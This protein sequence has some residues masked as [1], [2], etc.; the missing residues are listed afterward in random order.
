VDTL[1]AL[2]GPLDVS[3]DHLVGLDAAPAAPSATRA[4]ATP[5]AAKPTA[6]RPRSRK[7]A[8]VG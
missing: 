1:A 7:A 4:H 2:A 6:K 3:L 8:P 5:P